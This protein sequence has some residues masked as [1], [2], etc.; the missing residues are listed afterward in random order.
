MSYPS[1]LLR[2]AAA[3]LVVPLTTA[4]ARA[5]SDDITH[6]NTLATAAAEAGATDPLTESR[7]FAV[8]HLAMHDAVNAVERRFEPFAWRAAPVRHAS[9]AAAAA[10]AAEVVLAELLPAHAATFKAALDTRLSSVADVEARRAGVVVGRRA[11]RAVL[12][13]RAD[14]GAS[15]AVVYT[16]RDTPGDY[17]PTPPDLTPAMFVQWGGI[18]PF[19]LEAAAQ[20][21]PVPP[22]V[23]ESSAARLEADEIRDVGGEPSQRSAEQS[24]IARFWYENSTQGWN[25]IARA[26]VQGREMDLWDQARFY[27]LV[28]VAMADGFIAG[29]EAK[30][31]Y[32]YWR[33]VTAIRASGR[34]DWLSYLPTPPVPDYPST[35]TV[36]GAA[37]AT[38][39]ARLLG[40][41]LVPFSMTSGAPYPGITR[42]FWCLSEAAHENGASR[43]L[44]GIHFAS[45]VRAGYQQGEQVGQWAVDHLLR[46]VGAPAD[47]QQ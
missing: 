34:G 1:V 47:S 17:R 5:A 4:P 22:P 6:W 7:I 10:A 39:M 40:T 36:L 8:L 12:A 11:A 21:R 24:E 20:F 42:T 25:R 30:Y 37:A 13:A 16:P 43:M 18:T 35:H 15:R 26:V 46:P 38:T 33:P 32:R 14:D 9:A 31:H 19:S 27:A 41:D 29:F 45:A 23:P 44:A 3:C 28:N 2:V